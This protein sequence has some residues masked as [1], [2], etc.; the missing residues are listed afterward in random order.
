[1]KRCW[2]FSLSFYCNNNNIYSLHMNLILCS[3]PQQDK[4]SLTV[5]KK[6]WVPSS[7]TSFFLFFCIIILVCTHKTQ[8]TGA[9]LEKRIDSKEIVNDQKNR[10]NFR[11]RKKKYREFLISFGFFLRKA[12]KLYCIFS[13][14]SLSDLFFFIFFL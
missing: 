4:N 14:F 2:I 11:K 5:M 6:T 3:P 9:S 12:T 7:R 8:I 1:M 10:V 13:F